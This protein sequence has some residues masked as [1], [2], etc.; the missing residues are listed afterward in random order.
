VATVHEIAELGI[1]DPETIVTPAIHV[2]HIV[3]IARSATQ[4][5]GF[6]SA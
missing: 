2:S 3:M 6:K 5:G 4:A 1:L